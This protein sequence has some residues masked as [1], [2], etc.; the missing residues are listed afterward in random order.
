MNG[1][2]ANNLQTATAVLL[3]GNN[4]AKVARLSEFLGL[5]FISKR[6]RKRGF[7]VSQLLMS[8]GVG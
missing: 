3:S 8:G 4:F 5:S 6:R 2:W 7:T 1:L